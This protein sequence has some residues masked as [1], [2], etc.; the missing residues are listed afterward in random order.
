M[1]LCEDYSEYCTDEERIRAG[2]DAVIKFFFSRSSL[3]LHGCI[4]ALSIPRYKL[5]LRYRQCRGTSF[6]HLACEIRPR[7]RVHTQSGR[8]TSLDHLR[9]DVCC[10]LVRV[11]ELSEFISTAS[12]YIIH[13]T[14]SR[15]Q[16]RFRNLPCARY[17]LPSPL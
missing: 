16:L 17:Q 8:A 9:K 4:V 11:L 14:D 1:R 5:M 15:T 2:F 12:F 6:D 10:V 13:T 3:S 7:W